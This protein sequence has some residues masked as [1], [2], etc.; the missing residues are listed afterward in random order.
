MYYKKNRELQLLL[1]RRANKKNVESIVKIFIETIETID[2]CNALD[3]YMTLHVISN[4]YHKKSVKDYPCLTSRLT[5]IMDT[6]YGEIRWKSES[7]KRITTSMVFVNYNGE[8][9]SI[10]EI[11][12]MFEDQQDPYYDVVIKRVASLYSD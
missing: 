10:K 1:R 3:N 5:K 11:Y 7:K 12:G 4:W 6:L 2:F 9:H 8:S